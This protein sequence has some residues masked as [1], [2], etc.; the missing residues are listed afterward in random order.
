MTSTSPFA[1][2][3]EGAAQGFQFTQG[4]KDKA[5]ARAREDERFQWEREDYAWTKEERERLRAEGI[6]DRGWTRE[7]RARQREVWGQD[8]QDRTTRRAAESE[9]RNWTGRVRDRT[10]T[11]WGREDEKYQFEKQ[12]RDML[13]GLFSDEA[14]QPS[15]EIEPRAPTDQAP[16]DRPSI[17]TDVAAPRPDAPGATAVAPKADVTPAAPPASSPP[18]RMAPPE[19]P[20]LDI[21]TLA[22]D[23][24]P[25]SAVYDTPPAA[26]PPAAPPTATPPTAPV[27]APNAAPPVAQAPVALPTYD[28]APS[29]MPMS[30]AQGAAPS[31]APGIL[32]TQPPQGASQSAPLTRKAPPLP[33]SSTVR[34]APVVAD[35]SSRENRNTFAAR[36][37]GANDRLTGLAADADRANASM[38]VGIDPIS[39]ETLTDDGR[40]EAEAYVR[41]VQRRIGAVQR[42]EPPQPAAP[43]QERAIGPY[44]RRAMSAGVEDLSNAEQA[45][46][47]AA[48]LEMKHNPFTNQPLTPQDERDYYQAVDVVEEQLRRAE[49]AAASESPSQPPSPTPE[50][51]AFPLT[52]TERVPQANYQ[53]PNA[54]SRPDATPA[55]VAPGI[56]PDAAPSGAVPQAQKQTPPSP[57]VERFGPDVTPGVSAV[58]SMPQM[59]PP[60]ADPVPA[61]PRPSG[62]IS[63][64]A[65]AAPPARPQAPGILPQKDTT[66]S[67]PPRP[68]PSI[69]L[70][71]SNPAAVEAAPAAQATAAVAPTQQT[72]EGTPEESVEAV[73][74]AAVSAG[75]PGAGASP[76]QQDRMAAAFVEDYT[77]RRARKII[78]FY[79]ARGQFE[80]AN[81]FRGFLKD[82]QV[83]E[84]MG[85]WSKA[86]IAASNGDEREFVEQISR[87]YNTKGYYDD[88]YSIDPDGTGFARDANGEIIPG[89]AKITFV[90]DRTGESF[91]QQVDGQG[92]L[93]RLGIDHLSVEQVF[94]RGWAEYKTGRE[95]ALEREPSAKEITDA[96]KVLSEGAVSG[97]NSNFNSLS[98]SEKRAQAIEL[99]TGRNAAPGI[100]DVPLYGAK[101]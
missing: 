19:A 28:P 85:H 1:A 38:Q 42:P 96:I 84:G 24:A 77:T 99:L 69:G 67:A 94:E 60:S 52:R 55:R 17:G 46:I 16:T 15:G 63:R 22:G 64:V 97:S 13:S 26:P 34:P 30:P 79:E 23:P 61:A 66:W 72:P 27:A 93:Y 50:A 43:Q 53:I 49:M 8:D 71:S 92:D 73:R 2:F 29:V 80:K 74:A 33:A 54:P 68:A 39:G 35:K 91:T 41:N 44:Q 7:S 12:E 90:N 100:S 81:A 65:A 25:R 95:A 36:E 45:D 18:A 3:I 5:R 75:G 62:P 37:A 10:E 11:L 70:P 82:K 4:L 78:S 83:R 101:Q 86:I 59:R 9:E 88:G 47:A 56:L 57:A 40:A 89:S 6:E 21:G 87:A 76:Q 51:S 31:M 32:D 98:P 14:P 20:K 58:M 48:A